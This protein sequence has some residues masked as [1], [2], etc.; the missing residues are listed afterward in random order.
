MKLTLDPPSG[1]SD[2][3]LDV[4]FKVETDMSD[5]IEIQFFN[6]TTNETLEILSVAQGYIF[7]EYTVITKNTNVVEGF[8]NIF[9][10][11]KMNEK[12]K[13]Y[14]RIEI[15]CTTKISKGDTTV[16]EVSTIFFYNESQS[17]DAN[18]I[19]F[20]LIVDNAN[21]DL[22]NNVPLKMCII[23]NDDKKYEM[24]I[25]S[26]DGRSMCTFDIF[27][28]KGKNDI[29]LPSEIIWHDLQIIHNYNKKFQI[30]W[31]KFEGVNH[32]R[33]MNRKYIP[34]ENTNITFNARTM[35]PKPQTRLGPTG[36][37]LPQ[38]FILSHRYFVHTW[39]DYSAFG[40]QKIAKDIRTERAKLIYSVETMDISKK[41]D[42]GEVN[43]LSVPPVQE[44]ADP[45]QRLVLN[46][47]RQVYN[48][49][50]VITRSDQSFYKSSVTSA[51]KTQPS[52]KKKGCGCSRKKNA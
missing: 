40:E 15:K 26:S 4:S 14:I 6:I 44:L 24:A 47:Y 51:A 22:E 46:A 13:D 42:T 48:Q 9:N 16:E 3:Y 29:Y 32:M 11:D 8:I 41:K 21:L 18:I 30:Y 52:E 27:A 10:K 45:R 34:I 12:L 43:T 33:F 19:P 28:K 36:I 20:D 5:K 1:H 50:K 17:L 31:A 23:S 7:E 49:K 35:K 39:K 25:R 38:D 2:S 37:D